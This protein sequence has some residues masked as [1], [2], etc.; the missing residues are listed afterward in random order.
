MPSPPTSRR[1]RLSLGQRPRPGNEG[2][3]AD[4]TSFL[5]RTPN[6]VVLTVP[7]ALNPLIIDRDL[8]SF[9]V[10]GDENTAFCFVGDVP[11][12]MA[13]QGQGYEHIVER[14]A[15]AREVCS[16]LGIRLFALFA[17]LDTEN[18]SEFRE[19]FIDMIHLRPRAYPLVAQLVYDGIEDLIG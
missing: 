10:E 16:R 7:T 13:G 1:A 2:I 17:A 6:T 5:E 3:R 9:L 12:Q 19:H 8:S 11:Y 14:N 18:L 4:L 15:I